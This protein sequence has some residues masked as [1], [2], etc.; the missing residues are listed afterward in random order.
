MLRAVML[1]FGTKWKDSLPFFEFSYNNSY[2][3]LKISFVWD[4][5]SEV[6]VVGLDMIRDMSDKGDGVFLKMSPFKGT[7]IFGNKGKTSPR[8]YQPDPSHVLQL[9]E[10]ELDETLSYFE[11]PILILDRKDKKL[12]NNSIQTVKLLWSKHGVEE[13]TWELEQDMRQRYPE[14]FV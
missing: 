13:E 11:R 4:D 12:R 2:Q 10:A 7:I 5:F 8:K 9:D 3:E 14:I 1:D 6:P